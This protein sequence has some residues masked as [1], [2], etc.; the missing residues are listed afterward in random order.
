MGDR[1]VSDS[2][3]TALAAFF[4]KILAGLITG[5]AGCTFYSTEN[6]LVA[7]VRLTTMITMD[8]KVVS[9]IKCPFMI[10]VT[11]SVQLNFFRNRC[12]ILAQV[13]S[14]IFKASS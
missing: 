9:I 14:Y 7:G 4:Y 5:W 3:F 12:W 6:D 11:Q 13:A 2:F 8:A 1:T 10:P